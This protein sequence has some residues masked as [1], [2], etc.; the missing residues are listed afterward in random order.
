M[1][2]AIVTAAAQ[3]LPELPLSPDLESRI[4]R[5]SGRL[6][7]DKVPLLLCR[8]PVYL[9]LIDLMTQSLSLSPLHGHLLLL[10]NAGSGEHVVLRVACEMAQWRLVDLTTHAGS[11]YK[12]AMAAMIPA[13]CAAGLGRGRFVLAFDDDCMGQWSGNAWYESLAYAII[14]GEVMSLLSKK[15]RQR[16]E[17]A[18]IAHARSEQHLRVFQSPSPNPISNLPFPISHFPSLSSLFYREIRIH[19]FSLRRMRTVIFVLRFGVAREMSHS[20]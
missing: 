20:V 1:H 12:A 17:P 16:V 19:G 2:K 11:S 13:I 4:H 5:V 3:P 15:Q 6:Q 14:S 8:A 18:L 7:L 9:P 10:G